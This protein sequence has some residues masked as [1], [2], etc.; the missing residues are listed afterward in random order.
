MLIRA[1]EPL[2]GLGVIEE[3]RGGRKGPVLLT[4]PG[5]VAQALALD[6]SCNGQPLYRSRRAGG[7]AQGSPCPRSWRVLASACPTPPPRTRLLRCASRWAAPPGS[8]SAGGSRL[9]EP[10]S[11]ALEDRSSLCG[12]VPARRWDTERPNRPASKTPFEAS[13][14]EAPR[15]PLIKKR[16]PWGWLLLGVLG[17]GA[18]V[19]IY[20]FQHAP[21]SLACQPSGD[22]QGR[23][24]QPGPYGQRLPGGPAPGHRERQGAGAG[25]LAGRGGGQPRHQG[26]G[27]RPPGGCGHPGRAGPDGREP[28]A[29]GSGSGPGRSP[30][31]GRASWTGPA[32]TAC[33]PAWPPTGPSCA[34]RTPSWRTWCC[35]HPSRARSRR[36]SR[37]WARP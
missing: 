31:Q 30:G 21:L 18:G 6:L 34:T 26:P 8:R 29:G 25:G 36:S 13:M 20:G 33:A 37:R 3:R 27:H 23:G 14:A 28:A 24:A 5:K 22:L 35:A 16:F 10:R 11:S 7:P 4:G 1:C 19:A 2:E 9:G 17:L 32:W 15:R 12:P